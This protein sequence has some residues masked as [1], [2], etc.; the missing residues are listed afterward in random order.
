MSILHHILYLIIIV[1]N[2]L[3]DLGRVHPGHIVLHVPVRRGE[4]FKS[5]NLTILLLP[6][7]IPQ[8]QKKQQL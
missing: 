1:H 7:I 5:A 6:V 2:V 4:G 3:L 8:Q